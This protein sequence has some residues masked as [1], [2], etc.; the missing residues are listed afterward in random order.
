[1]SKECYRC[2]QL[3]NTINQ[4]KESNQKRLLLFDKIEKI[5]NKYN[6]YDEMDILLDGLLKCRLEKKERDGKIDNII[7]DNKENMDNDE[8]E[9]MKNKINNY[10]KRELPS[11]ISPDDKKRY[12]IDNENLILESNNKQYLEN[13]NIKANNVNE[14]V[15]NI[16]VIKDKDI[17]KKSST[18]KNIYTLDFAVEKF[19]NEITYK[20]FAND[21]NLNELISNIY[22]NNFNKIYLFHNLDNYINS[23]NK[24]YKEY[25]NNI[26]NIDTENKEKKMRLKIKYCYDYVNAIKDLDINKTTFTP[27]YFLK[28]KKKDFKTFIDYIRNYHLLE[29]EN[30]ETGT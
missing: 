29:K 21:S 26:F 16:E 17:I 19:K 7:D 28:M 2:K 20:A 8:P 22:K 14:I 1:M 12:K 9:Y 18:T 6:I 13:N 24:E 5:F 15:E 11:P 10:N 3:Q 30:L 25:I 27:S 4:I 23:K